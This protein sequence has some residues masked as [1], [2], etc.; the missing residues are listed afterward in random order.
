VIQDARNGLV[1][2]K[3][4]K[5]DYGVIFSDF[6]NLQVDTAATQALRAKHA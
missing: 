6:E 2:E 4:A 1:S 5:M 3:G